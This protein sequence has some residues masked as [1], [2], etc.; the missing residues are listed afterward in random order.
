MRGFDQDAGS[1]VSFRLGRDGFGLPLEQVREIVA[2]GAITQVPLAPAVIRGLS[3]L[4]GRVITLIDAATVFNRPLPPARAAE[5]RLALLLGPPWEH[6]GVYV[7]APVEIGQAAMERTPR[8]SMM[9]TSMTMA[10]AGGA[11]DRAPDRAPGGGTD[12]P[13]EPEDPD[14]VPAVGLATVAGGF[15][16]MVSARELVAFCEAKVLE[17]FRK[18][19]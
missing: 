12:S 5:D 8:T 3:N 4:R 19:N 16:H 1:C 6:L 18:R 7:H 15:I 17:R 2:A 11:S 9:G 13:R 10:A 14:D